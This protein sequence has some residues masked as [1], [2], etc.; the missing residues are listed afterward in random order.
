MNEFNAT[1]KPSPGFISQPT[2]SDSIGSAIDSAKIEF[3]IPKSD[4][5]RSLPQ[6]GTENVDV[7]VA[8]IE[9]KPLTKTSGSTVIIPDASPEPIVPLTLEEIKAKLDESVQKNY[10]RVFIPGRG[11]VSLRKLQEEAEALGNPA[12]A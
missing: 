3:I 7:K 6:V 12:T 9:H 2:S 10:R 8:V 4:S 1:K 5:N 11:W